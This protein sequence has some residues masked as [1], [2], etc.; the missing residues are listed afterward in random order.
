MKY[1]GKSDRVG[2]VYRSR[3]DAP[4]SYSSSCLR[5]KDQLC[6]A[7][8]FIPPSLVSTLFI[9]SSIHQPERCV[10]VYVP[11]DKRAKGGE[12]G[13]RKWSQCSEGNENPEALSQD[14]CPGPQP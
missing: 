4:N 13:M 1:G 10:S 14:A 2:S 6:E 3:H 5:V 11:V 8:C 7:S 12:Q 9:F